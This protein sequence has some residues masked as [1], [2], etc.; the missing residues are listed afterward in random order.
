MHVYVCTLL[1]HKI[2]K[3]A[4]KISATESQI[5]AKTMTKVSQCYLTADQLRKRIIKI[6]VIWKPPTTRKYNAQALK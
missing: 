1:T 6:E 5:I 4:N 2:Y 3:N